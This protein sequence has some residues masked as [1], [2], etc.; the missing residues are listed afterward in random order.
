MALTGPGHAEGARPWLFVVNATDRDTAYRTL[1]RLPTYHQWLRDIRTPDACPG[2]AEL[3]ADECHPGTSAPGTYIDLRDEQ[4]RA[5]AEPAAPGRL[6]APTAAPAPR[7][8][9]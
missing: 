8:S 6:P 1:T 2:D 4:A 3:V 9:R 7:R 5:L